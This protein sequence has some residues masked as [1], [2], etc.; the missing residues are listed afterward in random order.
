MA[1]ISIPVRELKVGDRYTRGN[2]TRT[3]V[4]EWAVPQQAE[5]TWVVA[6]RPTMGT[7][8]SPKGA[9]VLV[10][11]P[12]GVKAYRGFESADDTITIERS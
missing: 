12:N 7:F 4:P 6:E 5:V 8:M 9:R 1:E 3:S 10:E 11:L 2:L